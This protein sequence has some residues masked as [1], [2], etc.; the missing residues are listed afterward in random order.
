MNW[1][2]DEVC[3][4]KV[5]FWMTSFSK[6]LEWLK[7]KGIPHE[8]FLHAQVFGE[9]LPHLTDQELGELVCA[10]QLAVF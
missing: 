7:G 9:D 6:V 5:C 2:A 8:G 1:N 4:F 3:A 10:L